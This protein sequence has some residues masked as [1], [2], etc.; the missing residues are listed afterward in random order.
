[1][2]L[3]FVSKQIRPSTAADTASGSP[4]TE[5]DTKQNNFL[6]INLRYIVFVMPVK[7]I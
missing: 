2:A 4:S 6:I 3:V 1:M 7:G 5:A